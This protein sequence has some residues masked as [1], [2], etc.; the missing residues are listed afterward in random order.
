MKISS[1]FKV[2][3]SVLSLVSCIFLVGCQATGSGGSGGSGDAD[4][5][6]TKSDSAKFFT[7]AGAQGCAAGA[8]TGVL[9]CA[10]TNSSNK[11]ACMAIAATAGCAAGATTAY[12]IDQRRAKYSNKETSMNTIIKDVQDDNEKLRKRSVDL[13]AVMQD[14]QKTLNELSQ[15]IKIKQVDQKTARAQLRVIAA[16]QKLLDA[17]LKEL[18]DRNKQF[19][20]V[21]EMRKA[22]GGQDVRQLQ[23]QV[24]DLSAEKKS[25]Q[26]LKEIAYSQ[27]SSVNANMGQS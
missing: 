18:D 2:R 25:L 4:P 24:D 22:M 19:Q 23:R 15:Q 9:A 16:N 11:A 3:A 17:E 12:V 8:L 20:D 26:E 7:K 5:R 14:N 13:R 1:I 10:L 21:I 6:L 27:Y